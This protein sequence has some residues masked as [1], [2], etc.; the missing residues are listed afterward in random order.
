[1][2]E[3]FRMRVQF[4]AVNAAEEQMTAWEEPSEE[5]MR[6]ADVS[7]LVK[8]CVAY[9]A[10][11]RAIV[12][13]VLD[14]LRGKVIVGGEYRD[15][16]GQRVSCDAVG[17]ALARLFSRCIKTARRALATAESYGRLTGATVEGL[18]DLAD[19]LAQLE[20]HR[21]RVVSG[22]PWSDRP[23]PTLDPEQRRQLNERHERIRQARER[24]EPLPGEKLGDILAR[25]SAGGP[26]VPEE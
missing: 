23:L 16:A 15:S 5:P 21:G 12:G 25:L 3:T 6:A 4:A 8:V 2:S 19:A 22:W 13:T 10:D 24:G 11:M 18:A 1:M 14:E 9:P 26:L 7:A 17:H 20:E